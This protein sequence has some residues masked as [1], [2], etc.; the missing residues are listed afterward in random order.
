MLALVIEL[1]ILIGISTLFD[2]GAAA[3]AETYRESFAQKNP[4]P[5]E[6][7]LGFF[8]LG[9][10]TGLAI[11]VV[12]PE[13]ILPQV[14]MPYLGVILGPVVVGIAMHLWGRHQRSCGRATSRLATFYGG[15]A[16]T[17]GIA[18]VRYHFVR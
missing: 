18:L 10:C 5:V 16:L 7:S 6:A 11:T 4:G 9:V 2:V 12:L 3:F 8:V 14:S 17:L 15:F 1:L 13:R